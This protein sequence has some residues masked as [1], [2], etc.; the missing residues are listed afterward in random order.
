MRCY[1]VR[2]YFTMD[3]CYQAMYAD[4]PGIAGKGPY[5]F[6]GTEGLYDCYDFFNN[7][8]YR[9]GY[10]Q[11]LDEASKYLYICWK[12]YIWPKFYNG[13]VCFTDERL[14]DDEAANNQL[15]FQAFAD[16]LGPI[17][18][19]LR[20]SDTKFSLLIKNQE[21]NKENLLGQIKSSS[22][23]KFNDTPQN[24]GDFSD[25][26]HNS[27]VTKNEASTDGGTLLSRLNEVEDNLKRLYEDWSNEFR[28]F[29]F[30]SVQ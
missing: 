2:T 25:N 8:F 3:D 11:L 7:V 10:T 28:K 13:A 22:V 15:M 24:G 23:Q 21:A 16:S 26:G 1:Y 12:N 20:A 29:I 17:I 14:T 30:W 5:G 27:T 19:W 9:V 4:T 6:H 18:A